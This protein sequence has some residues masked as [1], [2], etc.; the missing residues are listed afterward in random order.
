MCDLDPE[1]VD[2]TQVFAGSLQINS[3]VALRDRLFISRLPTRATLRNLNFCRNVSFQ[4][5]R[6][7][8]E[9]PCRRRLGRLP[10]SIEVHPEDLVAEKAMSAGAGQHFHKL[11]PGSASAAATAL[12]EALRQPGVRALCSGLRCT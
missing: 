12:T 8:L 7:D 6:Q 5:H 2:A 10:F 3:P 4:Q 1:G 11:I 9:R